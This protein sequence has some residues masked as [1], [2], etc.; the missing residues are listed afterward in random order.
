MDGS[1]ACG[2]GVGHGG[3]LQNL[4]IQAQNLFGEFTKQVLIDNHFSFLKA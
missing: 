1:Q 4:R 2:M 3:G